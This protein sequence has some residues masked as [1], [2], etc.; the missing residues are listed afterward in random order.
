MYLAELD[1]IFRQLGSRATNGHSAIPPELLDTFN[2]VHAEHMDFLLQIRLEV[3]LHYIYKDLN[4][5]FTKNAKYLE[6]FKITG[7]LKDLNSDGKMLYDTMGDV[8]K[9]PFH[10]GNKFLSSFTEV[11][12]M[13]KK[14]KANNANL[15]E[16]EGF[17]NLI[18]KNIY[19]SAASFLSHQREE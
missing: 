11:E 7:K 19:L 6:K 5:A 16:H 13:A 15:K 17:L 8:V 2:R 3:Q 10:D 14:G 4:A 9:R 1:T 18:K 12:D